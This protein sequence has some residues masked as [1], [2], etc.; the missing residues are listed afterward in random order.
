MTDPL[1]VAL[2]TLSLAVHVLATSG[3]QRDQQVEDVARILA[4]PT[5]AL[6][7]LTDAARGG[8]AA[9]VPAFRQ[10]RRGPPGPRCRNR[11]PRPSPLAARDGRRKRGVARRRALPSVVSRK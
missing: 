5:P 1:G 8:R 10:S 6:R 3:F 7:V 4:D 11:R 2:A 9:G